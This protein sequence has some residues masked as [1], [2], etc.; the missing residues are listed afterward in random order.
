MSDLLLNVKTNWAK[1]K[2]DGN[3]PF[4]KTIAQQPKLTAASGINAM[5]SESL[6]YPTGSVG[7]AFT[8]KTFSGK[9]K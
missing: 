1:V 9:R 7:N 3:G 5:T 6:R 4:Y 2:S 8:G